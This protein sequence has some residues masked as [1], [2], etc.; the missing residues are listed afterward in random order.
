[1]EQ[2]IQK[3]QLISEK[4][5]ILAKETGKNF[6][7]FEIAHINTDEVRLCRVL[8]E[9]INAMNGEA[10]LK[11]NYGYIPITHTVKLGEIAELINEFKKS[12]EN[13]IL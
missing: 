6:N 11:D 12:R 7:I 10:S 13:T 2:L 1:M 8:N 4:Y 9:L 5:Q 3:I